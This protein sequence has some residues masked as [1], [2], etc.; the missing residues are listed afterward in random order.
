MFAVKPSILLPET[1][2]MSQAAPIVSAPT[3]NQDL[4]AA[5]QY[6]VQRI[7]AG[8]SGA[9]IERELID[10]GLAPESAQTMVNDLVRTRLASRRRVALKN[11]GIGG[12]ICAAGVALTVLTF[13]FALQGG[14]HYVVA[15]GPAIFGG[16]QFCRG[17]VQLVTS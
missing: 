1:L 17:F 12:L 13:T 5:Y 16:I 11:M 6:A 15:Y 14:G 9:T 4:R 2:L 7:V 3:V 10:N 8:A